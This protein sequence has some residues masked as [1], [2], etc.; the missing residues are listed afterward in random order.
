MYS[1]ILTITLLANQPTGNPPKFLE[2][3]A[4]AGVADQADCKRLMSYAVSFWVRKY[5][6][7]GVYVS[8]VPS[9]VRAG[10]VQP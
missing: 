2:T 7:Q 1:L 4:V 3:V 9:C 6:E 5:A 10:S 8:A